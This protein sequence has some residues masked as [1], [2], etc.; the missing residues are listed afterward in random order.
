MDSIGFLLIVCAVLAIVA[1]TALL[2][3]RRRQPDANRDQVDP[4]A[5]ADRPGERPLH[6]DPDPEGL[7]GGRARFTPPKR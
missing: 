7:A 1:V 3:T 2:L 5:T 6:R 4:Q